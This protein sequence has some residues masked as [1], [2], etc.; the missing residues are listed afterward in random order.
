MSETIDTTT[1]PARTS[2]E[3]EAFVVEVWNA[4]C[5][6]PDEQVTAY[7]QLVDDFGFPRSVWP[8]R[9]AMLSFRH[10]PP[11]EGEYALHCHRDPTTLLEESVARM[12]DD[13]PEFPRF[14][15]D[16][17]RQEYWIAEQ[18]ITLRRPT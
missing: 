15:L 16:M 9:Y 5:A 10:L 6:Y 13:D 8:Y 14:A 2:D 7:Q 4:F 11:D 17:D 18:D 12:A 1:V 3:R